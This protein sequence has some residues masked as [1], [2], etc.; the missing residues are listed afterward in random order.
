MDEARLRTFT[1]L[2]GALTAISLI[3]VAVVLY[4]FPA[5]TEHLFSWTIQP[6][7]TALFLG[8]GYGGGAYLFTRMALDPDWRRYEAVIPG[9]WL[10][11]VLVFASTLIHL[12]R[13]H[14]GQ[15]AFYVWFF[16][17]GLLPFVLPALWLLH[18]RLTPPEDT[19]YVGRAVPRWVRLICAVA[20]L[21]SLALGLAMFVTPERIV[22]LWPWDVT[23]LT[24]RVMGASYVLAGG[25]G[26]GL[27][28]R[29]DWLAWEVPIVSQLATYILLLLALPRAWSDLQSG[30]PLTPIFIVSAIALTS[31]L[32][33]L[34]VWY[35]RR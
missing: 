1:R 18:R 9:I 19:F 21:S 35:R 25:L 15:V 27:S 30:N 8:A 11:T 5:D 32:S 24:A 23:P 33:A 6:P 4:G 28:R 17:Y 2:V 20:G 34:L 10:F 14:H 22:A 29:A 26:L 3:G 12:D 16:G 13:F 31:A 7:L